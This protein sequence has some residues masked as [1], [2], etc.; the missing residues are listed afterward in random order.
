MI[1]EVKDRLNI[2]ELASANPEINNNNLMDPIYLFKDE[3]WD[4]IRN[5]YEERIPFGNIHT[6][7]RNIHFLNPEVFKGL[8]MPQ[9]DI[10]HEQT[11]AS[12]A[13]T[14]LSDPTLRAR[15]VASALDLKLFAP[16]E[17]QQLNL[18]E[19]TYNGLLNEYLS[20]DD[21]SQ[22]IY[23]I[24][25]LKILFPEKAAEIENSDRLW[26][27]FK[28]TQIYHLNES[29][30]GFKRINAFATAGTI[31]FVFPEKFE[32]YKKDIVDRNEWENTMEDLRSD[33]DKD[34]EMALHTAP[35]IRLLAAEKVQLTNRGI[36]LTM[37]KPKV[38]LIQETNIPERRRF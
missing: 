8:H 3:H 6:E 31:K 5:A 35:W 38:S 13:Q 27:W 15:L 36:V 4:K 9:E 34:F 12:G 7:Y 16:S 23:S 25:N 1:A 10:L 18:G 19:E 26:N 11:A 14:Y 20:N 29:R 32:E 21:I 28:D 22:N 30:S 17:Y 37:P 24:C 2:K 33:I